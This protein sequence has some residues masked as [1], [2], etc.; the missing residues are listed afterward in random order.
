MAYIREDIVSDGHGWLGAPKYI[1][2]HETAN[3]GA[4]AQNHRD[5]WSRDDTYA[6][7][8][9]CDWREII[10]TVPYNRICWHVGNA[11]DFTIGIEICHAQSAADFRKAWDNAVYWTK[12]MMAE[13]GLPASKVVSHDYCSR[14]WGGSDHTDPIGY[15]KKFGKSWDDF[16]AAIKGASP[17]PPKVDKTQPE[18]RVRV[19]GRWLPAMFGHV[20]SGGSSDAYAGIYGRSIEFL[21]V[22]GA[23]YRVKTKDGGWLPW[24]T[25]YNVNDLDKGC[26]GDGSDITGVE[27]ANSK[28]R[29]AVHAKG[30]T[31][32]ADMVGQKDTGGSSDKYAGNGWSAIDAI[33]IR[34]A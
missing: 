17:A 25:G 10:H 8:A 28:M 20:D 6:V 3:P 7:H 2:I 30:G 26:A 4:T 5:Y 1:V 18:Y 19:D 23:K 33:R 32:F 31:W 14:T 12:K 9:V 34:K 24:V 27:I 29:F 16:I 11:N 13:F 22:K 21:A 15:F